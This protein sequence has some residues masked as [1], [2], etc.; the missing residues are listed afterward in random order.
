M[1]LGDEKLQLAARPQLIRKRPQ[2]V[3]HIWTLVSNPDLKF[4]NKM[5]RLHQLG[6]DLGAYL[7]WISPLFHSLLS[8]PL[9]FR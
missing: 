8:F 3:T 7:L 4:K 5:M 9:S 2:F 6:E 1:G